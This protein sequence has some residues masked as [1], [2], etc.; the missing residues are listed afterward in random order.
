MG[1]GCKYHCN[2]DLVCEGCS[3]VS[4]TFI[5]LL[6]IGFFFFFFQSCICG[7]WSHVKC[8]CFLVF[9]FSLGFSLLFSCMYVGYHCML[10]SFSFS[11][12]VFH[13]YSGHFFLKCHVEG[14]KNFL[15]AFQLYLKIWK[16][17]VGLYDVFS[18][19][20]TWMEQH[21]GKIILGRCFLGL[22]P[23]KWW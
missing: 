20:P 11:F 23:Y 7:L 10:R 19:M 16:I 8:F 2:V 17:K 9:C 1:W 5:L 4:L 15:G 6:V 12:W 21:V 13:F 14:K 18:T 22:N 3:C